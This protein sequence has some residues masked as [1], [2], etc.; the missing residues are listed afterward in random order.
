[1]TQAAAY[2][3]RF[4]N[5]FQQIADGVAFF[6]TLQLLPLVIFSIL[7]FWKE[8]HILFIITFGIAFITGM[9]APNIISGEHETTALGVSLGALLI[10]YALFC[11]AMAFRL[12][13]W[14]GSE[15]E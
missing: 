3:E 11:A 13:F 14:R 10:G 12:M 1:V 7:A 5:I 4:L 6:S 2:V 8:N 15:S 9:N